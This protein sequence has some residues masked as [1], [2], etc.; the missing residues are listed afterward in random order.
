MKIIYII[1]LIIII[2]IGY[3]IYY[4]ENYINEPYITV[5]TELGLCNRLRVLLS[6]LYK[7]NNE[8]KKLR[9]I[10]GVNRDCPG[11]FSDLFENIENVEISYTN[12]NNYDYDTYKEENQEYKNEQ[13]KYYKL[14]KPVQS[15]QKEID[16]VKNLLNNKY[17]ACH[18]RRTDIL[19]YSWAVEK[20]VTDDKYIDFIN[21][22]PNDYKIYIATDC[23][24]TQ[25]KFI[26]IYGDRLVY[27]KIE[28]S[29]S[30]RQTLLEDAVIDLYVCANANYFM[31]SY[32]SSFTDTINELHK[33]N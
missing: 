13:F 18:I 16:R 5:R 17:V 28:D 27:K 24:D 3:N 29:T 15:I 20:L 7:A 14:L 21:S 31:G 11:K 25:K 6:Y 2:I 22:Y 8:G 19:N 4:V 23:K 12:D 9:F 33:L 30:F 10:W 32:F 1:L 26:D